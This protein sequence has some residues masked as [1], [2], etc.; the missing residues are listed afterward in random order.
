MK[1]DKYDEAVEISQS[2]DPDAFH[3]AAPKQT[4]SSSQP[5]S[6]AK[7][8]AS[9]V[10]SNSSKSTAVKDKQYDEEVEFSGDDD[11]SIDTRASGERKYS[12]AMAVPAT[13]NEMV[14]PQ[15]LH[16]T[17]NAPAKTDSNS[18][19]NKAKPSAGSDVSSSEEED[20]EEG[21]EGSYE[22]IDG[23]YNPKDYAN[24]Q[25]ST[26]VRELFQY[27]ERYK[28]QEVE[29]NTMLRCFVPE[30]IPAIGEMDG[31]IKIPRPDGKDDELGLKVIDE[32]AAYQSDPVILELQMRAGIKRAQLGEVSV[33]SIDGAQSNPAAIDN[34]VNSIKET[35]RT[36]PPPQVHYR[37]NMPDIEQL[38]DV[39]PEEFE[40]FLDSAVA[41][42]AA[43]NQ[44]PYARVNNPAVQVLPSPDLDLSLGEYVKVL[45]AILNIPVYDNP[46][47]SLHVMFSLF[48]E[49]R[50]N[51]HFQARLGDDNPNLGGMNNEFN[52]YGNADVME[53]NG[54][55]TPPHY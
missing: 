15:A 37:K 21:A 31:F 16:P 44:G 5:Q 22:Q 18:M 26:E 23:A 33:R 51:P 9:M 47:E 10:S 52:N 6:Q 53:M 48:Q 8:G 42:A 29:L 7:G 3:M 11:E 46:I 36:K 20:D 25:V 14:K 27:I 32:P 13:K 45:C 35:H 28:P 39:W 24:L 55:S 30:Y 34:W 49:F 17:A 43:Q 1:N 40:Q 54:N 41:A 4:V 12:S 2:M 50:N 19:A 38:M